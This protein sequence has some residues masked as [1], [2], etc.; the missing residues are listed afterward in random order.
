LNFQRESTP[1]SVDTDKGSRDKFDIIHTENGLND[2]VLGEFT[3]T[4]GMKKKNKVYAE[5][6]H[7][8]GKL[9]LTPFRYREHKV[10]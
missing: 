2:L 7:K 6:I 1:A 8:K 9:N 10:E 5:M 3:T 4:N